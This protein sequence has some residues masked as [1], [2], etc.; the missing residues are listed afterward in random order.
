MRK[1]W[2][3]EAWDE[4]IE[5]Q[6]KDKI[7]LKKINNLIKDINRNGYNCKGKLEPLKGDKTI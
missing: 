5:W 4:Y 7:T 2:H 6:T 1:I 3:D